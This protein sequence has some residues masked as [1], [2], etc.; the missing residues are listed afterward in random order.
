VWQAQPDPNAPD[1][2]VPSWGKEPVLNNLTM[3]GVRELASFE[4][5][6]LSDTTSIGIGG[7]KEIDI[8]PGSLPRTLFAATLCAECLLLFVTIYFGA[9]AREAASSQSFPVAG[10]LFSAFAKA[11][12]TLFVFGIAL[13]VPVIASL[14]ILLVSRKWEFLLLTMLTGSAVYWIF[15]VLQQ[16]HYFGDF[17]WTRSVLGRVLIPKSESTADRSPQL[18]EEAPKS[19]H[20]RV[21]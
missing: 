20:S 15:R 7:E 6:Q 2:F 9:F 21:A 5:P 10:T 19:T 11:G 13:C 14:G 12:G 4:L 1:N 17:G 3:E 8:S 18:G 16:K